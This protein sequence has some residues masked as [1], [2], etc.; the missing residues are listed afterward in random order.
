MAPVAT[1]PV[2]KEAWRSEEDA[3]ILRLVAQIGS[4]WS[5]VSQ[6]IPGRSEA[7]IRNRYLR[8]EK[9]Q[10]AAAGEARAL[11][12]ELASICAE[13]LARPETWASGAADERAAD[14]DAMGVTALGPSGAPTGPP[15]ALLFSS[16]T[17]LY[18]VCSE[19]WLRKEEVAANLFPTR[20]PSL[21]QTRPCR[22]DESCYPLPL[23]R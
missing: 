5:Q 13:D 6:H 2:R 18:A 14:D 9:Q 4:K 16:L 10:A 7:A 20:L 3:V 17:E 22:V 8:L 15:P 11:E 19:R 12:S 21:T 23:H 1:Q